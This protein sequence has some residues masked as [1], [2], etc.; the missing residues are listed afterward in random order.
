MIYIGSIKKQISGVPEAQMKKLM[1]YTDLYAIELKDF[2]DVWIW[3]D[4]KTAKGFWVERVLLSCTV[5]KYEISDAKPISSFFNK[6][7]GKLYIKLNIPATLKEHRV[8]E[9]RADKNKYLEKK[10]GKVY[11]LVK[12]LQ[13]DKVLKYYK[14][15]KPLE[16]ILAFKKYEKGGYIFTDVADISKPEE[17]YVNFSDNLHYFLKDIQQIERSVAMMLDATSDDLAY[18]PWNR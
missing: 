1:T 10:D 13:L 16:N 3:V 9:V 2:S 17:A 7:T 5:S 12:D 11:F 15:D 6:N 8:T 4:L 14:V 18:E